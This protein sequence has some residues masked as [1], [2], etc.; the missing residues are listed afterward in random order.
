VARGAGAPMLGGMRTFLYL[1]LA[2]AIW[3]PSL[4]LLFRA[5]PADFATPMAALQV[6]EWNDPDTTVLREVNPEWDL[7]W[8]MF[9]VLACT[10]LAVDDP[11]YLA[12]IDRIIDETL[13]REQTEGHRYFLLEYGQNGEFR[14]RAGRSL[15]VDGEIAMMLAVRQRVQHDP[16]RGAALRERIDRI[17]GQLERGPVL[18]GESYPNEV[19]VF[20]NAVAVAA[21]QIADRT[22]HTDHH[23]LV[24]RWLAS[25]RAHFIDQRTGLLVS[26]TTH[27]GRVIEGPEGSTIWLVAAM[28]REVDP[29]FARD[30]Y[31]RAKHELAGSVLGFAWAREWPDSWPGRADVDSGPTIPIIGANA[32]SSGMAFIGAAAFGDRDYLAALLASIQLAGFP[33]ENKGHLG[34][35]AGNRLSDAVVLYA[36]TLA[37]RSS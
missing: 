13:D 3:L 28:L 18:F 20:C 2:T 21:I 30:Q 23:E 29:A 4:H 12:S 15:F 17:A 9:D 34:F 14:D 24:A 7:M 35:A 31:D 22:E 5:A 16:Q 26:R 1:L 32:G 36:L 6:D 27:D 33:V 11:Q 8:R 37:G 25:A 19:W 10:H